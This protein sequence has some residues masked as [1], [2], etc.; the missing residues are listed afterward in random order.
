MLH[1]WETH[2]KH[3]PA[4]PQFSTEP[5]GKGAAAEVKDRTTQ[6]PEEAADS[7]DDEAGD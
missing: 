2:L 7:A 5:P 6:N 4:N 1:Y 3:P